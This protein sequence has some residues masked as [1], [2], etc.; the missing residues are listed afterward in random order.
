MTLSELEK[1]AGL[2]GEEKLIFRQYAAN[3]FQGAQ[4]LGEPDISFLQPWYRVVEYADTFGA[5][6]AINKMICPKRPVDFNLEKGPEIR[7]YDS[8]AGPIPIICV[9]DTADFE[10][11]VTNVAYQGVRPAHLSETGA[12]FLSGKTTRFIILSAKP[13]SNVPAA[14]LGLPDEARWAEQS[15]LLRRGHECTHYFTKQTFGI[16]NNILHDEIMADFIGMYETFGFYRAEWFLRFMGIVEGS[17]GR[18]SFYTENLPE[19]VRRAVSRLAELSARSLEQ[20]SQTDG[21]RAMTIAERIEEMCRA[22]LE[23]YVVKGDSNIT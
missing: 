5:D 17:G 2:N 21:F 8:F 1:E 3:R 10:Q 18:L 4:R 11:L 7:I 23:M 16:S 20:W 12:S 9:Y 22:G 6:Q 13:Y 14:E 19:R 15:L